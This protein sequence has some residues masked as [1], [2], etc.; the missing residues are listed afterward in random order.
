VTVPL[1]PSSE[2]SHVFAADAGS[3]H[4]ITAESLHEPVASASVGI[5]RVR[6]GDQS[7]VLKVVEH[8]SEGHANWRSGD[9]VHHWY[10]WRREIDAYE[11][12]LL[13]SLPTEF[14]AP[15]CHLVA[16]GPDGSV[17]LWLEDMGRRS[18]TRWSVGAHN[19]AAR[20]F[21]IMQGAS[22]VG[23]R[24]PDQVWLS[25]RWLHDYLAQ[26]DGDLQLLDDPLAWRHPL[27][28]TAFPVPP[29]EQAKAMRR[30]QSLFLDALERLPRTLSHL[31]LHPAN[32]FGD[33]HGMTVAIDWSFVG[34]GAIGED[35]GNLV[36]D[37]VLDFHVDP[38]DIDDLY[39]AVAAG[40]EE[41]LRDAGWDGP[42]AAVRLGLAATM[43]A[44]YAWILPAL[45]RAAAE[46]RDQLNRRPIEEAVDAWAPAID[47]LLGRADEARE[48][49]HAS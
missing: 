18:A 33:E 44:K 48:L 8:S 3:F 26:R 37:A 4:G 20:H 24:L 27:V 36:A 25:R 5:W 21:G 47:F 19:V 13:A 23:D 6:L 16:P 34:L 7:A 45:L 41:G 28:A 17:A 30:N 12:G 43:A 46:G 14:R 32:L 49:A 31:D 9:D 15:E 11:S 2:L 10:Y 1:L 35:A 22:V 38:A 39:Q 29:V 40:Y 42:S